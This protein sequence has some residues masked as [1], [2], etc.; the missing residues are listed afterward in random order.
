MFQRRRIGVPLAEAAISHPSVVPEAAALIGVDWGTS[1]VRVM[2]LAADGRVL[3]QRADPRGAG[4]LTAP[5]FRG[6][7]EQVAGDWLAEAPVLICG[8]AG[9]RGK[10]REAGYR[11]CPASLADIAGGLVEPETDGEVFIVPG[12]SQTED[13]A[14]S[15]VMRGEETQIMGLW[16]DGAGWA[17]APGTHSKWIRVEEGRIVSF[18]TFVTGELFAAVSQSAIL[19]ASLDSAAGDDEAF[20]RGVERGLSDRAVT[21]AL[22]SVRVGML[23]GRLAPEAAPD[24][25]S[26]L[27]IGAEIAAQQ[28]VADAGPITLI[29]AAELSRRYGMALEIAGHPRPAVANAAEVTA[30]GLWR[31]WQART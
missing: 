5:A 24:Y 29:G 31:I 6:V 23:G 19:S 13:G 15:D 18:R 10:W 17:V 9:A 22:F 20:R 12:V 1:N 21:A 27:L 26:G 25:L 7:L 8:M 4:E 11:P 14:L 16:G 28:D 2:R 30:R 3:E